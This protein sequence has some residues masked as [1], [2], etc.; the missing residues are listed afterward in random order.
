MAVASTL[1]EEAASFGQKLLSGTARRSDVEKGAQR[2]EEAS[3]LIERNASRAAKLINDFKEVAVYQTSSRRRQVPAAGRGGGS[4]AHR[5]ADVQ[6]P[7]L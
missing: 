3:Q 6:D 5:Q 7:G 4:T 1:T 2:I